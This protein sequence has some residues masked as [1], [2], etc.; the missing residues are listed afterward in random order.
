MNMKRLIIILSFLL[1]A[2]IILFFTATKAGSKS[3]T[4]IQGE[5]TTTILDTGARCAAKVTYRV[6]GK[7]NFCLEF[8][9]FFSFNPILLHD[10]FSS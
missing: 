4:P 7:Y 2:K 3:G 5:R 6:Q 9:D 8:L 1:L 10:T